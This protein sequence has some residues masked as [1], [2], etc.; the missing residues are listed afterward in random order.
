MRP[1]DRPPPAMAPRVQFYHNTADRLALAHE[2]VAGACARGRK[3]ALRCTD[4]TQLRRLDQALWTAVPLDFVPH[5]GA[6]SALAVETPVVLG[7][8]DEPCPWPH[9]D[10]LFN[11]ADDLPAEADGFRMV[12][13][14]VGRDAAEVHAARLR[15]A[16]YRQRGYDLKAFD[17]ERRV[18]L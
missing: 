3:V 12:V 1:E 15:W 10:M 11:L 6:G 2:L 8:A 14:I 9:A 13:E 5:V 4:S 18:A 7:A 17:A 16:A